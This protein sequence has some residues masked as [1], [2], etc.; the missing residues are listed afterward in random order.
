M[1]I[2]DYGCFPVLS[3]ITINTPYSAPVL[4]VFLLSLLLPVVTF[5]IDLDTL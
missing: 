1:S 4:D 5:C 3:R 2:Y